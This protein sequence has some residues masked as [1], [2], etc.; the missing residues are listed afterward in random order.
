MASSTL[1]EHESE[2]APGVGD[3]IHFILCPLLLLLLSIL[4][5]IRVFPVSEFFAS[6]GQSIEFQLQ[7]QSLNEN[8]G[9]ISFK[10][11]WFDIL[12]VQG[13]LKSLL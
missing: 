6:G 11:D 9:L 2:Q 7:H 8:S 13:T 1:D 3:A 10:I 4:P 12:A 5:S